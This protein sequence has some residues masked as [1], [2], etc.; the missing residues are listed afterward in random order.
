MLLAVAV[1][2]AVTMLAAPGPTEEVT[3][4]IFFRFICLAKATAVW[5]MPCSF[6]PCQTFSRRVSCLSAC[7]KPTTLPWPGSMMT[8]STKGCSTPS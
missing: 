6:L 3:A 2:A 7:P 5:A 4:M 1:A 8:P